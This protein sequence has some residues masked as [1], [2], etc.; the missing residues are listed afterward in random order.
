MHPTPSLLLFQC[1]AFVLG[2]IVGSFLNVVIYRLPAGLSVNEPRRSFCP[3]CKAQI[4]WYHN[5]PL[6]SWLLLRGK[7]ARCAAPIA[8]RYFAVELL[9]AALFLV[10]WN[11]C[12]AAG[13]F[14]LVLPL[15]VLLAAAAAAS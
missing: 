3:H 14:G 11:R 6:F 13:A 7:C 8:F 15:W 12:E 1:F 9:T 5:I 10:F 2:A 4:A